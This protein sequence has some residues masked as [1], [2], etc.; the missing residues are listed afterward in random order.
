[1]VVTM[2]VPGH[3]GVS[4]NEYADAIAKYHAGKGVDWDGIRCM[5]DYVQHRVV[6]YGHDQAGGEWCPTNRGVYRD[7]KAQTMEWVRTK[8]DATRARMLMGMA[9][10]DMWTEV[11]TRT[12]EGCNT[13]RRRAERKDKEGNKSCRD[14]GRAAPP[15][16]ATDGGEVGHAEK[17]EVAADAALRKVRAWEERVSLAYGM[18]IGRIAKVEGDARCAF[19]RLTVVRLRA[20]AGALSACDGSLTH[21]QGLRIDVETRICLKWQ[22]LGGAKTGVET[23][24]VDT[25]RNK[26]L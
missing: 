25:R 20:A 12:T 10:E 17:A 24:S 8:L 23:P 19:L 21:S 3:R 22:L 15:T 13:A 14:G 16:A 6:E 2:W 26:F 18:R 11:M 4:C 9:A 1:M 7:A 5:L